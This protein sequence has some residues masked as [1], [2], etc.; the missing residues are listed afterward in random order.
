MLL[1]E[2]QRHNFYI[3]YSKPVVQLWRKKD[4]DT[5]HQLDKQNLYIWYGQ[6]D[7]ATGKRDGL[8]RSEGAFNL[9]EGF[10]RNGKLVY[11]RV[12]RFQEHTLF[13]RTGLWEHEKL[14]EQR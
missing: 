5:H 11:G 2:C 10:W 9:K 1:A 8:G 6:L 4:A 14:V 13:G 12:L 7:Q 3:D